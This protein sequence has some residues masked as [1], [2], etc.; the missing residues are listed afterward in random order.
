MG[1]PLLNGNL[2]VDLPQYS[3]G[4]IMISWDLKKSD[5]M[6]YSWDIPSG[7]HSQFA[8]EHGPVE[9][10]DLPIEN[11]DFPLFLCMFTRG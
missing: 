3:M 9:I 8:I 11:G 5:S 6:G 4:F 1:Y 2:V 10:V 7:K